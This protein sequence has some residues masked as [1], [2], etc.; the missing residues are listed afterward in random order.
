MYSTYGDLK[1]SSKH[2]ADQVLRFARNNNRIACKRGLLEY[3]FDLGQ[4]HAFLRK[5]A[6][7]WFIRSAIKHELVL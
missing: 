3:L 2:I 1:I 7:R 6:Q 5:H 4:A